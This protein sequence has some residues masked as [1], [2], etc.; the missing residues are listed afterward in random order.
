[1]KVINVIPLARGIFREE[2]SYFTSQDVLPGSI[3]TVPVRGRKI[4]ALVVAAE[5]ATEA[6]A[7]IKASSY[8]IK[9]VEFVRTKRFFLPEFIEAAH[10]TARYFASTTGEVI[11]SFTPQAALLEGTKLKEVAPKSRGT[12]RQKGLKQEKFVLQLPEEER[13]SAYKSLIREEFAKQSSVF[14]CLPTIQDI[15]IVLDSLE[16]GIKEYTFVLHSGIPKKKL[17]ATWNAAATERHPILIIATGTFFSL[18]RADISTIILD[19]ENSRSYKTFSRP[20]LDIRIFAELFAERLGSKLIFGDI[21]LRPEL[22]WRYEQGEFE[23]FAPLKF[24]SMSTATQMIVDM[25]QYK[26]ETLHGTL[27]SLSAQLREMIEATRRENAHLFIFVGRRGLYPVTVCSD[28]GSLVLCTQ[29][30]APM[31]LHK[32]DDRSRN[33]FVCHKCGTAA[34]ADTRCKSCGSWRLKTLGIGID[35]VHEEIAKDF[36]G[37]KVFKLEGDTVKTQKRAVDIRDAFYASPGSILLGTGMALPYLNRKVARSAVLGIDSLFALPDFRINEKVMNIL[38]ELREKT[39]THFL[40]QTRHEHLKL[41]DH[42]I[43]GNLLE[44]YRDEIAD[45]KTFGYPPFHTLI[46]VTWSG[47]QQFAKQETEVLSKLLSPYEHIIYPAFIQEIRGLHR[48]NILIKL[49][50]GMWVEDNLLNILR[51][52]PPSF[53]VRVD[54]EDIL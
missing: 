23:A 38:L 12:A 1:M 9:K 35:R 37:I 25:K 34:S 41:F 42:L 20:F 7:A 30:S 44:F 48:I 53:A 24:R 43:R 2:L 11:Q 39:L 29:C 27:T 15:E 50:R 18:P 36:D 46:K 3:V 47:K 26:Q 4:N 31:V 54:P 49:E 8:A 10:D 6:K 32:K 21:L 33:I 19:K 13:L 28:C 40:V 14:F 45:R 5:D 52:L 22:I 16:R 51:S 17:L